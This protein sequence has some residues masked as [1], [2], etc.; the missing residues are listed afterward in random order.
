M[1]AFD[2]IVAGGGIAGLTAGA[3]AA[4]G[5]AK[6]LVLEGAP[7]F[8]GRARTREEGGFAF[9]FGPHALYQGG[10]AIRTLDALGVKPVGRKPV[11]KNASLIRDG[12]LHLAPQ[13]L[14]DL[15]LTSAMSMGDK[16]AFGGAAAKLSKD[17][18]GLPGETVGE[19]VA[20]LTP[21]L[22][23]Q[24]AIKALIRVSSY[25]NAPGVMDAQAAFDQFRLAN[26]G[27]LYLDGGWSRLVAQVA[28]AAR[29]AGAELRT[30]ARL[31][32]V[33]A[34]DGGWRVALANGE[35]FD[36]GAVVLTVSPQEAAELT[37]LQALKDAALKAIPIRAAS[38]DVGLTRLPA[39]ER[40]F[41][42]GLD[43]PIYFSVHSHTAKG[44]APDGGAMIHVSRYLGAEEGATRATRAELEGVLD[45]VQ[46]G[47]REVLAQE[48]WLP[49]AH[50]THDLPQAARGGLTGRR[51]VD[52]AP[53]LY[54]AGDWVGEEGMLSDCAFASGALAGTRA[55]AARARTKAA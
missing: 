12:K 15:A 13:G 24:S 50:V 25:S 18:A 31:A 8:G 17:F 55:G 2:V 16:F 9:N 5:G 51:S 6:T 54:V 49:M 11:L 53:G 26:K 1:G 44:L 43:V 3:F 19:G 35:A 40:G 23:A 20:R 14:A 29:A 46:P 10:A 33:R 52:V 48:Q 34:Q 7:S 39:P 27:V 4:R 37:E 41:A 30:E 38:L 22:V 47:W 32:S 36:A 21:N 28:E 45:L 42:L